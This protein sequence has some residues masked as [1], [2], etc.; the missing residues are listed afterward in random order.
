MHRPAMFCLVLLTACVQGANQQGALDSDEDGLSDAF[1]EQIGTAP[2]RA[3]SDT[4][5]FADGV[6]YLRFFDPV[7]VSD[8]PYTGEYPRGPL[9]GRVLAEG[10]EEGQI[11]ENW[12]GNDQHLQPLQL[13][14]FFGNVVL[15]EVAADW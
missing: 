9:P 5:G 3:D 2:N 8:Y 10:W 1:E 13:H 15:I 4:D 7:D 14:R 6:E 12:T 11:T